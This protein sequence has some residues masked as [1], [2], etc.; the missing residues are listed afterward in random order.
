MEEVAVLGDHAE[1]LAQGYGGQVADVDPADAYGALVGVIEAG[2][3][4][5][6]GRLAGAGGAD[7]GDGLAGFGAERDAVQDLGAPAGVERGDLF[8]RGEGDLVGGRVAE[9]DVLEL[10]GDRPLGHLSGVRLLVD[11][12]LE[13]EHLEDALEADEGAHDL[14]AGPGQGGQ[15]RVEAGEE[16]GEG[17]DGSRV[18]GAFDGEV[19]AQ[20]VDE[21][22]GEGRDE[23]ERGDE[24]GLRHGRADADVPYAGCAGGELGGLVTGPAEQL[25]QRGAGRREPLGH[26]GSHGRVVRGRLA[27]EPGHPCT[28]APRGHHE[29]RQEYEGEERD[30]PGQREH[31]GEGE[32]QGHD[33]AD[34]AGERVAERSL[35]ADHVVVEPADEGAGAGPREEG[36]RHALHV[37]EDGGAQV[38]DQTLAEIGREPPGDEAEARLRE[39]DHGDEEC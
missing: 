3:E 12:R 17:D 34:H 14:D 22:E 27:L 18:E 19:A 37:V 16:Q 21:R 36:H 10:H 38:E 7:E 23:G 11:Q 8:E 24:R 4:L 5:G 29:H 28:H 30:L 9:A 20:A 15:R 35:R 2:H 26:P 39:G 25:D 1:G 32:E 31:D 13:V 33:I 6:D